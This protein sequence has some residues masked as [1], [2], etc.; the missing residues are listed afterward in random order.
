MEF[1]AFGLC[2]FGI[3]T[4]IYLVVGR[5]AKNPTIRDWLPPPPP[6]SL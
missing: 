4:I 6:G 2:A 3:E 1:G 5:P